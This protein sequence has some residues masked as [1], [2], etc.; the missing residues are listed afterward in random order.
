MKGKYRSK[1]IDFLSRFYSKYYNIVS[2]N[3]DLIL[4]GIVGF[5]TNIAVAHISDL[6]SHNELTN[7]GLTVIIG[8]IASKI[9]FAFLFHRDYRQMYTDETTGRI[10]YPVLKQIIKKIVFATA[11]FNIVDNVVKFFL[12]LELLESEFQ[13]IQAALVSSITSAALSYLIINLIVKYTRVFS[14]TNRNMS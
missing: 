11:V 8:F 9:A 1:T 13:P 6:Y 14:S 4:S 7:S 2:F 12:L 5:L 10:V 3:K